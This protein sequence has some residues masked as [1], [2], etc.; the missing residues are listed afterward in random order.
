MQILMTAEARQR[1]HSR[2]SS[3]GAELDII[4]FEVDGTFQRNGTPVP[5]EAVDPEVF[6]L[7]LDA[8]SGPNPGA[9][10]TV[11]GPVRRHSQGD[12][13]RRTWPSR[14]TSR[15]MAASR[16]RW[17]CRRRV[18]CPIRTVAASGVR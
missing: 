18:S 10:A 11:S 15:P 16:A 14:R 4:T 13:V 6:W 5:A 1:T 17:A 7:S 9:L 2:L 8:Y 3:L 12:M